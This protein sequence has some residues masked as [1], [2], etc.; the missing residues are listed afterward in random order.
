MDGLEKNAR[1]MNFDNKVFLE[2]FELRSKLTQN[3]GN[4]CRG[5]PL[6]V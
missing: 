2:L 5:L 4:P 6:F 3:R 1:L